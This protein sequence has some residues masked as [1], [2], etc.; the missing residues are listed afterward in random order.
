MVGRGRIVVP[1]VVS[2]APVVF[3][4]LLQNSAESK[5]YSQ[6]YLFF[7]ILTVRT[8]KSCQLKQLSIM[9]FFYKVMTHLEENIEGK[10]LLT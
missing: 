9:S 4:G 6:H 5:K 10:N 7:G 2:L 3:S 1:R 8:E